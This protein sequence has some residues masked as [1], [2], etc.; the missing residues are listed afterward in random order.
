MRQLYNQVPQTAWVS[1]SWSWSQLGDKM[2]A[3]GPA[4]DRGLWALSDPRLS[5][6]AKMRKK[7]YYGQKNLGS[8][9][10]SLFPSS[11]HLSHTTSINPF[12]NKV[13]GIYFQRSVFVRSLKSSLL[14]T[15]FLHV[16]V[17]WVYNIL[18]ILNTIY[19]LI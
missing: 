6:P 19:L 3:W 12:Q 14:L 8:I 7:C 1:S 4:A 13:W 15:M 2:P 11:T 5:N 18:P 16:Y 10:S 9:C 17:L